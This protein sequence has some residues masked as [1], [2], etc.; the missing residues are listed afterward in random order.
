MSGGLTRR[1]ELFAVPSACIDSPEEEAGPEHHQ[2]PPETAAFFTWSS[3]A[4]VARVPYEANLHR[5]KRSVVSCRAR[6]LPSS[7]ARSPAHFRC[8][9]SVRD[10]LELD[11]LPGPLPAPTG[12][13]HRLAEVGNIRLIWSRSAD[14]SGNRRLRKLNADFITQSLAAPQT[15]RALHKRSSLRREGDDPRSAPSARQTHGQKASEASE[16]AGRS[17]DLCLVYG[18]LHFAD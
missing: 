4:A 12:P 6:T 11:V 7:R 8:L 2:L 15:F 10:R 13:L 5:Q 9:L 16:A 3:S 17:S 1:S 18:D 14:S